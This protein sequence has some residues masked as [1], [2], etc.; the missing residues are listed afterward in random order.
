MMTNQRETMKHKKITIIGGGN[1]GTAIAEGLINSGEVQSGHLTVTRRR[2]ELLQRLREKGVNTTSDNS[3][4]VREAD[5]VLLAV[6]PYQVLEILR[7]IT[8]QL[9]GEKVLI[10]LV[11]GVELRELAAV[12]GPGIPLFRAMPNTAIALRE[13]MTLISTNGSSDAHKQMVVELFEKMGRTAVIP[14]E[15]MAAATVLASCGIAYALRYIR[16]AMQGGVEIGFGAELAQFITAQTVLGAARL[17]LET[18]NHPEKEIDKVTTPR[19]VTITGLNEMENKGFS[20]SLIQGL[21]ASYKK[22]EKLENPG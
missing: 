22:I 3:G 21:L 18:G 9:S 19:G 15:L 14:D 8:P 4:A 12:T 6:K 20:A 11:A 7:Q 5:V 10:S 2:T 16:A 17:V 13:S 1:L